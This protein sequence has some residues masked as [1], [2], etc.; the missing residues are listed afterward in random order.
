MGKGKK[1]NSE[2]YQ[3]KELETALVLETDGIDSTFLP[4]AGFRAILE[5]TNFVTKVVNMFLADFIEQGRRNVIALRE[6]ITNE[7]KEKIEKNGKDAAAFIQR[8]LSRT[9]YKATAILVLNS[10]FYVLNEPMS[11][12]ILR[13]FSELLEFESRP[14]D[15]PYHDGRGGARKPSGYFRTLEDFIRFTNKVDE[16]LPLWK[17]VTKYFERESYDAGCVNSVKNLAWFKSLSKDCDRIP[18]DLLNR[19]F[20]RQ[21]DGGDEF[22]PIA[23]AIEHA[24]QE[25][26]IKKKNGSSYTLSTLK[27]YYD[28]GKPLLAATPKTE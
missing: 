8:H 11:K 18:D 25:L 17:E 3:H 22:W 7:E 14:P 23:F 21:S 9:L 12:Q 19:V 13:G 28:R 15:L 24:C 16:L 1:S 20:K 10:Y 4:D 27:Q 5:E 2:E 6:S 26:S